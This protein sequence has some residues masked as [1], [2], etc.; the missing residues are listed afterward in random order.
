MLESL[1]AIKEVPDPFGPDALGHRLSTIIRVAR[2]STMLHEQS[3][4][5]DLFLSC[6]GS[7]AASTPG[8]LNSQVKG[9]RSATTPATRVSTIGQENSDG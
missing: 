5:L 3:N 2:A 8:I 9:C 1:L 7:S 4:D 6:L